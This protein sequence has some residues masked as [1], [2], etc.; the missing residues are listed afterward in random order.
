[1]LFAKHW[2]TVDWELLLNSRKLTLLDHSIP[3]VL[4]VCAKWKK[5]RMWM[6]QLFILW[7]KDKFLGA[8]WVVW[9]PVP[10]GPVGSEPP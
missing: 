9:M 5:Y 10:S 8:L 1:M 3:I 2:N 4:G 7:R 6:V